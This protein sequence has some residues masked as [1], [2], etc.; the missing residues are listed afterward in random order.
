VKQFSAK[1]YIF[2]NADIHHANRV[3]NHLNIIDLFDGV[4]DILALEFVNKPRR[5]AYQ[6]ALS[7]VGNPIPNYCMLIDDRII[8]L[9]PAKEIGITTVLV[10]EEIQ[11]PAVDYVIQSMNEILI[12]VPGLT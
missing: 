4:I 9:G 6:K 12:K 10:G 3:L 7:L 8:N 5:E 2:T 11:D 1:R